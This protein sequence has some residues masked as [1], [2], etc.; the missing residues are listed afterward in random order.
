[1]LKTLCLMIGLCSAIT[2]KP[3]VQDGDTVI[4]DGRTIRLMG[5]DAEELNEPHG[6]A[7]RYEL[8]RI[9][10]NNHI[11]CQLTGGKS[12]NRYIGV[13][14]IN[15]KDIGAELIRRG[16]ALDCFHYSNGKYRHL[17]PAGIRN[18]LASKGYC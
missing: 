16:Y 3:W 18:K 2:G 14:K 4:V 13:C 1:M 5:V 15:D 17:E 6:Y 8:L 12:Y 7:A 9:I 10:G 11:S